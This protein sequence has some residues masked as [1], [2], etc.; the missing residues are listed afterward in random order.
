MPD[1]APIEIFRPGR[2]TALNG[3]DLSFTE[4]DLI[5]AAAAYDPALAP[6]PLVVGHPHHDAPAYGWVKGLEFAGGRLRALP[7]EVEPQFAALVRNGRFKKVSASLFPPDHPANPKPGNWYVKHVGFLG[8]AAP[9]VPGLKP[10]SFAE[11]HA[12]TFEFAFEGGYAL[13]RLLRNLREWFIGAAGVTR[14]DEVLP[15]HLIEDIEA[16]ARAPTEIDPA[17]AFAATQRDPSMTAAELQAREERLAADQAVL[18]AERAR[19]TA[20]AAEFA[21]RDAALADAE[22]TRRRAEITEFVV[23]QVQ[24]GRLLPRHQAGLV[25]LIQTLP[26][27]QVLEFATGD[28][29]ASL[30]AAEFLREFITTLPVQVDFAERGALEDEA[31][32]SF[33]APAGYR[34][35]PDRL[36]I[37]RQALAWQ[38]A[39]PGT[40]YAAAVAAVS[41]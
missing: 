38:R 20:Q 12:P 19:L 33:V 41:R 2:F 34:V 9:A 8:A 27:D 7:G 29:T 31:L 36:E 37:H 22:R 16:A 17:T 6:A 5:A 35:A 21:A 28:G 26:A 10:V 24:A 4:A 25:E 1:L 11:D 39:H 30:P 32:P 40:D 3:A 18:A 13:A 15:G 23:G 14:A